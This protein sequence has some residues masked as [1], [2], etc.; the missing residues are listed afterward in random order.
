MI[1]HRIENVDLVW[2]S[3]FIDI[4]QEE[5][6]KLVSIKDIGCQAFQFYKEIKKRGLPFDYHGY[7]LDQNYVNLGLEYFP[8]LSNKVL[9][10]DFANLDEVKF[11]D[12]TVCSATIEHIDGWIEFLQKMLNTTS[13]IVVIRSFF[14]E[15]TKR[16]ICNHNGATDNYPIWQF[17]FSE[18][19]AVIRKSGFF[20]EIV[21][22]RYTNSLPKYL[23]V[24]PDGIVRTQYVI[25]ARR[26]GAKAD[27]SST[28]I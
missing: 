15:N 7:E 22:D 8:E 18:F 1:R 4:L 27:V 17:S 26:I 24:L 25:I 12:I 28:P 10:G 5:P 2:A 20:P 16:S 19:L 13:N 11:T 6:N 3:Q 23:D 14:G 9:V 21:R